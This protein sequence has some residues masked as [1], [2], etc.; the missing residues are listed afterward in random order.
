MVNIITATTVFTCFNTKWKKHTFIS[1][2]INITCGLVLHSWFFIEIQLNGIPFKKLAFVKSDKFVNPRKNAFLINWNILYYTIIYL[3]ILMNNWY[4]FI[5]IWR[6]KVPIVNIKFV[7]I[8]ISP[9]LFILSVD[10]SFEIFPK[11]NGLATILE[12]YASNFTISLP[13]TNK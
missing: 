8:S 6:I 4:T 5:N 2:N 13:L 7:N 1:I 9:V 12:S 3:E 10:Q 11:H